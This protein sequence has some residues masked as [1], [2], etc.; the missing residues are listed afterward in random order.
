MIVEQETLVYAALNLF[1][2]K[3]IIEPQF[4]ELKPLPE[5]R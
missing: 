4:A 2:T 1:F 5:I 3:I